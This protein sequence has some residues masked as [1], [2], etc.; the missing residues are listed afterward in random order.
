MGNVLSEEESAEQFL[1]EG[2]DLDSPEADK[3]IN[4]GTAA[5]VWQNAAEEKEEEEEGNAGQEVAMESSSDH[6]ERLDDGTTAARTAAA[7]GEHRGGRRQTE[8]PRQPPQKKLSY[9]QMAKMGYQELVN[10]IIR[11]PRADYKVRSSGSLIATF[12]EASFYADTL[13]AFVLLC[14]ISDGST[15]PTGLQLLWQAFHSNRLHPAHQARLQFG[16]FPLGARRTRLRSHSGR[17]LHARQLLGTRRSHSSVVL[18]AF[19]R[20]GR[21][22]L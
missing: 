9:I 1:E 3:E 22:C 10:A 4:Y 13:I 15:W 11:P 12:E 21:L 8:N 6:P 7:A 16:M 20:I 14:V 19:A 17:Y 18:L 5:P 2:F